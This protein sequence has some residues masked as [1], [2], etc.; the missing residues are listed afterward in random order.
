ME[1]VGVKDSDMPCI[2][3]FDSM[4]RLK[5]KYEGNVKDM[6]SAELEEFIA[7]YKANKLTPYTKSEEIPTD[8]GPLK[9][10]VGKNF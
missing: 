3:V 4:K 2:R 8:S 1:T 6:T 7:N 10:L 9:V 5:F